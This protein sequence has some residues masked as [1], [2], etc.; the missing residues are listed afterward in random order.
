MRCRAAAGARLELHDLLGALQP[1]NV[2]TALGRIEQAGGQYN[3]QARGRFETVHDMRWLVLFSGA[4]ANC[5]R[6]RLLA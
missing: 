5:Q 2:N 1:N 6:T 4:V 3:M